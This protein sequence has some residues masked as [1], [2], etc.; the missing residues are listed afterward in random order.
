MIPPTDETSK[1]IKIK[2]L[3]SIRAMSNTRYGCV[4]MV[5]LPITIGTIPFGGS[6]STMIV[7][8]QTRNVP[9]APPI[10]L[11]HDIWPSEPRLMELSTPAFPDDDTVT[12]RTY[13][14]TLSPFPEDDFDLP[15]YEDALLMDDE[16][17][18][19]LQSIEDSFAQMHVKSTK[20]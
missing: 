8:P 19:N 9:S 1:I 6:T 17:D 10:A 16:I 7:S 11:A 15:T 5:D 14:S 20:K 18:V 4:G 12:I 13:A 2:Y 3:I